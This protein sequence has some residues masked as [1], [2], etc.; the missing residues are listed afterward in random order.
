M[1]RDTIDTNFQVET[2]LRKEQYQKANIMIIEE[3][4]ITGNIKIEGYKDNNKI[5]IIIEKRKMRCDT[6]TYYPFILILNLHNLLSPS[7]S[8]EEKMVMRKSANKII[9]EY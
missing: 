7:R 8:E 3:K 1:E 2:T 6:S 4:K 5:L 9:R